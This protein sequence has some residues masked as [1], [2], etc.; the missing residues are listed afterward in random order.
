MLDPER[1]IDLWHPLLLFSFIKILMFSRCCRSVLCFLES[2][3]C[4]SGI[5]LFDFDVSSLKTLSPAGGTSSLYAFLF[6]YLQNTKIEFEANSLLF[7]LHL[8][9]YSLGPWPWE[10]LGFNSYHWTMI[11]ASAFSCPRGV[12]Q[13]DFHSIK[14]GCFLFVFTI[15]FK[16]L[17]INSC[18]YTNIFC[19]TFWLQ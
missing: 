14:N 15:A 8:Y 17:K 9:K 10:F 18:F 16:I 13:S 11:R 1:Q 12:A 6:I 19:R 4:H 7:H 5:S 3:C 2:F